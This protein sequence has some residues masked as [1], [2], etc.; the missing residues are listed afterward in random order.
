MFTRNEIHEMVG[1]D[2][3][4]FL[5]TVDSQP[6]AVCVDPEKNVDDKTIAIWPTQGTLNKLFKYFTNFSDTTLPYYKKVKTNHWMMEG[7]VSLNQIILDK[8]YVKRV[9]SELDREVT[10]VLKFKSYPE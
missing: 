8:E 3:R 2:L 9:S 6:V 4:S 10:M 5:P 7:F 1:G